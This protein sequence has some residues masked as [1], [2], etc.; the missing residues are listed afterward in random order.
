MAE[1]EPGVSD[2]RIGHIVQLGLNALKSLILVNGGACVALLTL[3]GHL[4]TSEKSKIPP[5]DLSGPLLSFAIALFFSVL[6]ACLAYL[7]E[8]FQVFGGA[9]FKQRNGR[10]PWAYTLVHAGVLFFALASLGLF[11]LGC[12][13]SVGVFREMSVVVIGK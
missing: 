6:V 4:A 9:I 13:Q 10:T 8:G 7:G 1:D 11:L 12:F 3:L 2:E 5:A